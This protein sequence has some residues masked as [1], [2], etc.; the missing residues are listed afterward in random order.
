MRKCL[1]IIIATIFFQCSFSQD[2]TGKRTQHDFDSLKLVLPKLFGNDRVD[3]LNALASKACD[4]P[5]DSWK[6]EADTARPY[7]TAANKEAKQIGYRKGLGQSF[8][9]L[10]T[11]DCMMFGFYAQTQRRFDDPLFNSAQQ[12]A[13]EAIS[14][15]EELK[16]YDILG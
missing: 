9:N 15:G 14:I 1:L 6:F 13:K 5:L 16:D 2:D 8:A 10:E 11:I 3:C 12:N 4:L 7:A